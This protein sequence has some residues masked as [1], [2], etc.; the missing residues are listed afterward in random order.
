MTH[1]SAILRGAASLLDLSAAPPRK[2]STVVMPSRR[3]GKMEAFRRAIKAAEADGDVVC[4]VTP[5]G[6]PGQRPS[7]WSG[8]G[9]AFARDWAALRGDSEAVFRNEWPASFDEPGSNHK[10]R[11]RKV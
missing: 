3:C 6:K 5:K 7:V 8:P 1:L 10:G 4:V 9:D 2:M 11:G